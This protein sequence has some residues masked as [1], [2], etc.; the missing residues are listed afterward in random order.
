ME[1][2]KELLDIFRLVLLVN[3]ETNYRCFFELYPHCHLIHIGIYKGENWEKVESDFKY[4]A[5]TLK[6]DLKSIQDKLQK[7]LNGGEK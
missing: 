2:Y 6:D 1:S 4:Y 5:G 3:I 7:I